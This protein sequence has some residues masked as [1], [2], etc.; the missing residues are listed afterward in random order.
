MTISVKA[1]KNMAFH[2]ILYL[3]FRFCQY[4]FT[5]C[6][7]MSLSVNAMDRQYGLVSAFENQIFGNRVDPACS[8]IIIT[9]LLYVVLISGNIKSPLNKEK[10]CINDRTF[11]GCCC[12]VCSR[13]LMLLHLYCTLYHGPLVSKI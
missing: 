11:L 12:G 3:C 13:E 6:D 10:S 1:T 5:K 9:N 4:T 8:Y 2:E 7:I